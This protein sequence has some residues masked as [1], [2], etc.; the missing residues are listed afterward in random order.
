MP[1]NLSTLK[2]YFSLVLG[3]VLPLLF[4]TATTLQAKENAAAVPQG[5]SQ[6]KTIK[7]FYDKTHLKSE[8]GFLRTKRHGPFKVYHYN[9][10]LKSERLYK[11][12]KLDGKYV[13]YYPSGQK[14]LE[15][16]YENNYLYGDVLEYREDGTLQEK[17]T[18]DGNLL[19]AI[20]HYD[21]KG[22]PVK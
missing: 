7:T 6:Y 9:G 5:K 11:N 19:T 12:G 2:K 13:D 18:Y 21:A 8:Q 10:K 20:Q 14:K 16:E 15:A 22:K 3:L 17:R 4:I 1:I